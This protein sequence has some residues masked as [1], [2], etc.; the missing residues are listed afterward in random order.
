SGVSI[1]PVTPQPQAGDTG[2]VDPALPQAAGAAPAI[3]PS[4]ASAP[5]VVVPPA[6]G[7]DPQQIYGAAPPAPV[8]VPAAGAAVQPETQGSGS[9][10]PR[11]TQ[12]PVQPNEQVLRSLSNN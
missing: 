10:R 4:S 1:Q 8:Q 2:A 11:R 9:Y 6:P 12:R 3:P 7:Q 5:G